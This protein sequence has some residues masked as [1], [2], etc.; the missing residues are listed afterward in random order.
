MVVAFSSHTLFQISCQ[1]NELLQLAKIAW[2]CSLNRQKSSKKTS[3][4]YWVLK[5]RPQPLR[6][7]VLLSELSRQCY[8]YLL[9]LNCLLFLHW[10]LGID[11]LV[12]L[13]GTWPVID[14]LDVTSNT[15][16]NSSKRRAWDPNGWGS[17]F[18]THWDNILLLDFLVFV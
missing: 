14:L 5:L 13:S 15:S 9:S 17:R 12:K 16:L 8:L 10:N 2:S 6:S 18:N 1:W 4:Q 7:Y 11:N 3:P